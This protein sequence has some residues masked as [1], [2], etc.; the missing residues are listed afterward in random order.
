MRTLSRRYRRRRIHALTVAV[1]SVLVLS[2]AGSSHAAPAAAPSSDCPWVTS[3]APVDQRV[4]QVLGLMT[5]DEKLGELHGDN[6]SAYAGTVPAVPRLCIPRLT[7][8]DSPAGVGHQMTGVTQLPAPV[9]DA[10]TWDSDLARQYGSV[11][12]SEQW[13][14]GDDV[15]LGPTVNIV[16]DPR[17]GRAFESYGEDPYLAG[18]IGSADVSGIQ[19][20]GEMAQLKHWAV[21]NQEANRNNSDDDAIIDQRVEQEIYL[22][23]FETIVKQAHPAS[24][25]CS[26]SFINGQPAC[27]D[28]Y[29]MK[30][31]LRD[32]WGYQGF[33]TS[34][35]GATH[36]TVPSAQARMNMEMPGDAY[37]GAPLKQTVQNGQ[38]SLDTVDDL[39][40]PVLTAMFQY[41]LFTK[42]PT[43]T[44]SSVVTTPEHAAVAR[45]V[46]EDGT[47]LL[48]NGGGLL[49]LSPD[50]TSSIAVIGRDA[51][52]EAL[53]TGGGS[54]AVAADSVVTPYQGIAARAGKNTTVRYAAGD[55]PDGALPTVPSSVLTPSSGTGAGLT[56]TYYRGMTLSGDPIATRDTELLDY[57]WNGSPPAPS[58]PAGQ[59]SAKYTGTLT[60]PSTGTYTFSVTSDDGSRLLVDGHQIIDNWRDQGGTTETGTVTL[61]AGRPVSIEVDYYQDGGGSMLDLGWQPP[62]G[63]SS[64]LQQ[65]VDVAKSSDVAVVFASDF[66]GEGSDLAD[67]DLPAE[68]NTLIQDVAAVNPHTVVVL[69]TGSA[70]TMPW[71]DSVQGVFE[72]WYPG[73]EDG[74]AIAALLF[75]DVNPSGKLPVTFPKSLRDVPAATTAQ[76]PGSGGKVQYSEGLDVGYRWYDDRHIDPLFAF[77]YGLSYTSFRIG[78]FKVSA[79]ATTSL[80]T[81]KASVDVT[82]TGRRAGSDVVQ[83]YVRDPAT[84]GEPPSQLKEFQKVALAPGQTRKVTFDVP[85][86]DFRTW[87]ETTRTW[88]VADGVYGLMV[89]D[90]SQDLPARGSVR[91]VRS[92]G[93]QGVTLNAPSI[94]P[95]R[96]FQVTGT[97]VN[98]ADVPVRN[99]AVTP[100]VPA[101]WTVDPATIRLPQAAPGSTTH[102]AFTVTPPAATAPGSRQVTLDAAFDEEKVGHGKVT[103]AVS[104]VTTPYTSWSA[105]F[106]NTGIS[107]DSDPGSANFDG[108]GYSY[109]AQQLAAV[110]IA[111]GRPVTAGPAAFTWPDVAPGTPDNIATQGQVIPL[112]G[113]GTTLSLL[114]AGGPGTQSGDFTVTYTDGTTSTA[115]VTLADWWVNAPATGDTL[116]ATTANWNQPPTG[117]GPHQVSVYATSLPLTA[118]KQVAYVTLPQLPGMHLFD[119]VIG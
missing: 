26:Y 98:D 12:G 27:Q 50:A 96:P 31:V 1:A 65:A 10:A 69:N 118:G 9:A 110:G 61:T 112:S 84:T 17:W 30:Q 36:S 14:K 99:V 77:G 32:Q 15:D 51:G 46:A 117:N 119:A 89:G 90:S 108:S 2:Q 21:Y 44:P 20:T 59:W 60:P 75:G 54:A 33:V 94:V 72:A 102:L 106:D 58:V 114:G 62:G 55:S 35:W 66:E 57:D 80:G 63:P 56:G 78:D 4:D 22:S 93:S 53:T 49:P 52:N 107:D 43:G 37:Y 28:P 40:R 5:L 39:V 34:D 101:G 76:W 71:L 97:F 11:V 111:P 3:T 67:I 100:G 47:V 73:Q 7:L 116:V 13:G 113:S 19:G 6:S 23:Q 42:P 48:K 68:E 85:A 41:H 18:Q 64:P 87:N 25:M 38:V 103:Q 95:A 91:V 45:K 104:N 82:N 79:P 16:R 8:D 92:Y 70:V 105:A 74:S 88:Q 81:V 24:L 86:S 29:I 109:S 83:L 115:T